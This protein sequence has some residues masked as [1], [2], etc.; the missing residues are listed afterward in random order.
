[1]S[2]TT[3]IPASTHYS[4]LKEFVMASYSF[5]AVLV[6]PEGVG[7]WTY[8]KIPPYISETFDTNGQVKVMGTINGYPFRS[9]ALPMGA[10]T[11]YLVVGKSMR[12]QVKVTQGDIVQVMLELD[13][14][15]RQ[16]V[17]PKDLEQA[18]VSQLFAKLAFEK[19]SY[20]HKKEHVNWILSTKQE[21]TR[22]IRIEKA[23]NLL[24][25]GKNPRVRKQ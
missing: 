4:Q 11:H 3:G 22:Q 20:S 24:A 5:E 25:Q 12:D 14:E 21:K 17:I 18:L 19:L 10:G 7:T 6:R 8:F 13:K 1:M 16:V 23:L 9:T 2:G 15:E